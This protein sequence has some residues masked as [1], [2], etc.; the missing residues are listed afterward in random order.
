MEEQKKPKR[1]RR[2]FSETIVPLSVYY[3][4]TGRCRGCGNM[5]ADTDRE[6][7]YY[8]C[9]VANLTAAKEPGHPQ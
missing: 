8:E 3:D 5:V 7:H 2:V 6:D 4:P 9:V 1:K